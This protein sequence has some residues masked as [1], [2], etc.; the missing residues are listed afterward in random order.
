MWKASKFAFIP[1]ISLHRPLKV[2]LKN[3]TTYVLSSDFEPI[4]PI[5]RQD[6]DT[7]IIFL[8]GNGVVYAS[9]VS[10]DWYRVSPMPVNIPTSSGS[11]V[12]EVP[13]YLP[14]EP[15]SPL[16]CTIQHEFCGSAFGKSGC[17][18]LS[19]LRDAVAGLASVFDTYYD[20]IL[21]GRRNG[22]S[23]A[24]TAAISYFI[25]MFF[26]SDKAINEIFSKL[27]SAALLSQ[28]ALIAA[29]QGPLEPNQW[30]QDITYAWNISLALIQGSIIDT[31][32]GPTDPDYLP[33]WVKFT[34][35]SLLKLCNNQVRIPFIG[36]TNLITKLTSRLQKILSTSH[37]SFSLVGLYSIFITGLVVTLIS[38]VLEPVSSFLSKKGHFRYAHSEW[39]TNTVLQLQRLAHEELG[40]G[41]WSGCA[42]TIPT[43]KALEVMASLD[44]TDIQHPVLSP[45]EK[46][47][48]PESGQMLEAPAEFQDTTV[49]AG[50]ADPRESTASAP[51]E[52]PDVTLEET[53][54]PKGDDSNVD[55]H[56]AEN[57]EGRNVSELKERENEVGTNRLRWEDGSPSLVHHTNVEVET[58]SSGHLSQSEAGKMNSAVAVS[59]TAAN[60]SAASALAS[61]SESSTP[62]GQLFSKREVVPST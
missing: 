55:F 34:S 12:I 60:V 2:H 38:Y 53:P 47:Q 42:D 13:A 37:G 5:T 46:E 32:Y 45:P 61:D 23:G 14:S 41:T 21:D 6:A 7:T 48:E 19:S 10:D 17:G 33:S 15:A 26:G 44:I 8:S 22:T 25:W 40:L 36:S 51:N 30:Q 58:I 3:H 4:T 62:S 39:T 35:P 56:E 50:S 49:S 18:P 11:G 52:I 16:G 59:A 54:E 31:A 24:E 57:T 43:T 28:Q 1:L 9:P 27:G 29:E 20:A